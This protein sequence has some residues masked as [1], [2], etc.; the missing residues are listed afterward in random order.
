M[1]H[2][3]GCHLNCS[4]DG[5]QSRAALHICCTQLSLQRQPFTRKQKSSWKRIFRVPLKHLL[6]EIFCWHWGSWNS[7]SSH[8]QQTGF[9]QTQQMHG[10]CALGPWE[11]ITA[12]PNLLGSSQWPQRVL[13]KQSAECFDSTEP[14]V[15]GRNLHSARFS[16]ERDGSSGKRS[17]WRHSQDLHHKTIRAHLFAEG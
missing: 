10:R 1:S 14:S 7:L 4:S 11:Q 2:V 13:C 5:F 15:C 8:Y 12:R 16:W 3:D 17:D 9:W 6:T